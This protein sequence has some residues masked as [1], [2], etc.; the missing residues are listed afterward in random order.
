MF[1]GVVPGAATSNERFVIAGGG[2]ANFNTHPDTN[3]LG[4]NLDT[5]KHEI[6]HALGFGA[7]WELNEVYNDGNPTNSSRTLDGGT[8]G[9][10]VGANA[11]AAWQN[12]YVGQSAATFIPVELAGGPGT[13]HGHWNEDDNFGQANTGIVRVSDGRDLRHELLTGFASNETAFLSQ[14]TIASFEDIGFIVVT[15]PEPSGLAVLGMLGLG[16]ALRRRR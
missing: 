16:I 7:L 3:G 5:I 14:T 12:E 15:V 1:S 13:A 11:L 4:L 9:Q 8:P 6:G 10:Y 2:N